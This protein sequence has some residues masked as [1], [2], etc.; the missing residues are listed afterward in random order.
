MEPEWRYKSYGDGTE[1]VWQGGLVA[2][3]YL[4]ERVIREKSR[5]RNWCIVLRTNGNTMY[6]KKVAGPFPDL[7]AAKAAYLMLRAALT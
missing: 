1:Q 3:L 7:D 2:P 6:P 5:R 4:I